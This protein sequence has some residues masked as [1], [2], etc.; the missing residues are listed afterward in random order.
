MRCT[1][2]I[3]NPKT[4]MGLVFL[5]CTLCILLEIDFSFTVP[6]SSPAENRIT[7]DSSALIPPIIKY[8]ATPSI[9]AQNN[10]TIKDSF[11]RPWFCATYRQAF[12]KPLFEIPDRHK[13]MSDAIT[14]SNEHLNGNIPIGHHGDPKCPHIAPKSSLECTGQASTCWSPGVRDT[15]CPSH[16]LCCFD[17]CVNICQSPPAPPR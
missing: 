10:R 15:D 14:K 7:P 12:C 5:M 13:E 17:G 11:G 6:I 3:T 2:K 8:W 9:F 16:G 1:S 4:K